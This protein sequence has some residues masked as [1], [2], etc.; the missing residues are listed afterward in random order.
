MKDLRQITVI[1]LGLLGG[2]ISQTILR[3]FSNVKV[4]G[5]T[6]RA[7]T[8]RKAGDI[9]ASAEIVSN[10]KNS[11]IGSNLVILATPIKTFEKIFEDIAESLDADA[12]VTDVG[13]TKV[14]PH[15]WAK[16]YLPKRVHYVGSHPVAGSE[17]RGLEYSRDDLFEYADCIITSTKDTDKQAIAKTSRF[18]K[19]MGCR[20]RMMN[21]SEHDRIYANVSHLPHMTAAALLNA[22]SYEHLQYC[23][24]GFIDTSRL[25]S[26]PSNIWVDILTTNSDNCIKG[27]TRLQSELEKFKE[28]IKSGQIKKIEKL[29]ET[30]REKRSKLIKYKLKTKELLP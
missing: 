11:V 18:W 3:C 6:H 16:K 13:S 9:T 15:R 22:N 26:S 19:Q 4:V 12:I 2:S 29:L 14:M 30:A 10:L 25:A 24:K 23:G 28:A 17:H 5:Y 1:G 20:I 21:P 7:S 8:R 27:I